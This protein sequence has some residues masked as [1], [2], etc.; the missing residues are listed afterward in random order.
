MK[1][2]KW[3]SAVR[4]VSVRGADSRSGSDRKGREE[5]RKVESCPDRGLMAVFDTAEEGEL[6]E[7]STAMA[8]VSARILMKSSLV[9][10][11]IF[12]HFEGDFLNR[13][14]MVKNQSHRSRPRNY[15]KPWEGIRLALIGSQ[16]YYEMTRWAQMITHSTTAFVL[17]A[18]NP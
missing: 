17:H 6:G 10:N 18:K 15:T 4:S 13:S 16:R 12:T 2:K 9:W 3:P 1:V 14:G 8:N 7:D 5:L 11:A